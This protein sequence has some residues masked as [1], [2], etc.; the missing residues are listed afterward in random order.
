MAHDDWRIRVRL[1]EE[2]RKGLLDRLGLGLRTRAQELA[3]EL[4]GR[5]LVVSHDEDDVFVYA[6][7]RGEA[8][9]ALAIVEAE[10]AEEGIEAGPGPIEHWLH[11]EERWDDE[12]EGPTH[13]EE[14]LAAGIA[15]WE[16]RV[17][18]HSRHEAHELTERL[19]REGYSVER[20][21]RF[22]IAG[23]STRE[24]ADELARRVHG[25]VEPSGRLVWETMPQNPF[26]V[27][28]GLG[29]TG[30]PL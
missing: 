24:E 6:A 16:V 17:E 30:T 14:L 22:V 1:P 13:E 21:F 27:F 29:G 8:E 23:A 25:E 12:P 2:H 19:E 9:Q 7:S 3:D 26:V 28:G 18:C 4:E 5:R 10:L 15:P 20:R 11:E